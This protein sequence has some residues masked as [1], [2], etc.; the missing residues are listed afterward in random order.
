MPRLYPGDLDRH[1]GRRGS[2]RGPIAAGAALALIAGCSGPKQPAENKAAA[3]EA[4]AASPA[5]NVA[6]PPPA[7]PTAPA[8]PE[9]T[10]A[11]AISASA[12]PAAEASAAAAVTVVEHYFAFIEARAYGEAW[13]LWDRGGAA[14]GKTKADFA[15]DFAHYRDYHGDV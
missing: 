3:N 15:R 6:A 5:G 2:V 10:P 11:N 4:P 12:T 9:A 14:S 13:R 1:A 7:A 8:A